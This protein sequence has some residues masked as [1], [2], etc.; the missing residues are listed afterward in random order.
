VCVCVPA[1]VL[2]LTCTCATYVCGGLLP[3][4]LPASWRQKVKVSTHVHVHVAA[5]VQLCTCHH[6]V[7]ALCTH[8]TGH[9]IAHTAHS[10]RPHRPLLGTRYS[11]LVSGR[12]LATRRWPSTMCCTYCPTTA[13]I[14]KLQHDCFV[15]AH[16]RFSCT[17]ATHAANKIDACDS[18]R[19][20]RS[21]SFVCTR[22]CLHA[23]LTLTFVLTN[24]CDARYRL[25][26]IMDATV[27]Q[28]DCSCASTDIPEG[29]GCSLRVAYCAYMLPENTS[30]F[31]KNPI[32]RYKARVWDLSHPEYSGASAGY[33]DMNAGATT[34]EDAQV[35]AANN[36]RQNFPA[37]SCGD[38]EPLVMVPGFMSSE[39]QCV[40]CL[41]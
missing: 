15:A 26:K 34:P 24:A 8:D 28:T 5:P 18:S 21:S 4:L 17:N 3:V 38:V 30:N 32:M 33:R 2:C 20:S 35:D 41:S 22:S 6:V 7:N 12:R 1:R 27:N 9:L 10:F 19:A 23:T 37:R 29:S 39:I 31:Q 25:L 11:L 36:L 13:T 14:C 16:T 40:V